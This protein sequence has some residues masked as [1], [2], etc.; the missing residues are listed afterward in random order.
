MCL[1]IFFCKSLAVTGNDIVNGSNGFTTMIKISPSSLTFL[2]IGTFRW[3]CVYQRPFH[4]RLRTLTVLQ[5]QS[6]YLL[7]HQLCV[8]RNL[9]LTMCSLK[10]ISLQNEWQQLCYNDNQN[11][12]FV[13]DFLY[14][15]VFCWLCV[16]WR[17][18]YHWHLR[19]IGWKNKR[20][21]K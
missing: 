6:V 18:L 2:Y 5:W 10:T 19:Q 15:G 8:H 20:T 7:Y 17:W 13:V 21:T 1:P 12:P 4:D 11:Y 9:P 14:I 3:L 16:N